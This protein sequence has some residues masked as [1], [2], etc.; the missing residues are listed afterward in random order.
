MKKAILAALFAIGT[1][2]LFVACNNGAYDADPVTNNSNVPNPLD[3]KNGPLM[4]AKLNGGQWTATV[5]TFNTSV[6]MALSGA[7]A[8]GK[9]MLIAI[10]N[11][12]GPKAYAI[13]GTTV[14]AQ[15]AVG[16]A[17]TS[18]TSGTVTITEQ[19]ES[20]VRGTFSWQG[21]NLTVTEG[22]FNLK[23]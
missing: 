3:P 18:A 23:K 10:F 12:T 4:T 8:D 17:A 15:W 22:S 19:T 7:T 2:T 14:Q 13:D 11:Y 20:N 1:S 9:Q 6:G 16:T 5:G 21:D